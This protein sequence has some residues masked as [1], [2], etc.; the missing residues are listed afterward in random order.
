MI[1][2]S[3]S[4]S[5]NGTQS[6]SQVSEYNGMSYIQRLESK[7]TLLNQENAWKEVGSI[8]DN[9][10]CKNGK[11]IMGKRD[12]GIKY[13]RSVK[14]KWRS[15]PTRPFILHEEAAENH[16][17][18]VKILTDVLQVE[19]EGKPDFLGINGLDLRLKKLAASQI[20]RFCR[21]EIHCRI[22]KEKCVIN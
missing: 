1:R 7:R 13:P 20:L 14:P 3:S 15:D 12:G 19:V 2:A 6:T 10:W 5:Q 9:L 22:S 18:N 17:M 21:L 8:L 4:N 11:E 16:V